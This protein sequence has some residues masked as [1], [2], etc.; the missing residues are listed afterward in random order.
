MCFSLS[1]I[2]G[3]GTYG[4]KPSLLLSEIS[5]F[6]SPKSCNYRKLSYMTPRHSVLNEAPGI[7]NF[8]LS[9]VLHA[10][11]PNIDEYVYV[12]TQLEMSLSLYH[13]D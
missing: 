4:K 5:L 13:Y 3:K 2:F 7:S 9:L 10:T 8:N 11:L 6:K 12:Y 1:E